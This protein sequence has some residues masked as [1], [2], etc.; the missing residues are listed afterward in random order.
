MLWLVPILLACAIVQS[1][2]V[3]GLV[4]NGIRPELVLVLVVGWGSMRGWE[5]GL[6]A[7]LI[8]GFF[9]DLTSAAPLGISMVRLGVIGL[10]AGLVVDRLARSSAVFPIVAAVAGSLGSFLLSVLGLQAAGWITGWEYAL[11]FAALPSA[12]IAG[13]CMA[14]AFPALRAL[15]RM[16]QRTEDLGPARE[17]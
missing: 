2:A 6:V 14:V 15:E 8:G 13:V 7:G 16:G 3:P 12:A 4:T 5:E 1:A 10:V 9:T 11:V 17:A